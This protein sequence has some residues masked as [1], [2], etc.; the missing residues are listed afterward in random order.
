[1]N[2]EEEEMENEEEGKGEQTSDKIK[3]Y[4]K[5][6]YE[7]HYA[8][9]IFDCVIPKLQHGNDGLVFTKDN[10]PYYPG[11]C[12]EIKKWKPENDNSIDFKIR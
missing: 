10:C 7:A 4:L 2:D 6:F 3:L 8:K 5:D 12:T 9:F 1:M 11:T